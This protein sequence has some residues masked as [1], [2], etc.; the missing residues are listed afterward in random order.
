VLHRSLVGFILAGMVALAIP[1]SGD[2]LQTHSVTATCSAFKALVAQTGVVDGNGKPH[3]DFVSWTT[4]EYHLAV[5]NVAYHDAESTSPKDICLEGTF[6]F[7]QSATVRTD[8]LVWDPVGACDTCGCAVARDI[9]D[10][11]AKKV[12]DAQRALVK[13]GLAISST[14]TDIACVR[15]TVK[16]PGKV[17]RDKL[18]AKATAYAK[19]QEKALERMFDKKQRSNGGSPG[20]DV[21][22]CNACTACAAGQQPSCSFCPP[23]Y[24]KVADKCFTPCGPLIAG[25]PPKPPFYENCGI[26]DTQQTVA[27]CEVRSQGMP[28]FSICSPKRNGACDGVP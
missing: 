7:S 4:A 21:P 20:P 19:L 27:C 26:S 23:P 2:D 24:I 6:T 25:N 18:L 9:Y 10:V 28:Y 13:E 17:V 16:D 8:R 22:D 5:N 15:R 14:Y 1:S 11:Q 3:P 12:A